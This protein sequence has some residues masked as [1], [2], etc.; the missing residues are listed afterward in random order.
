MTDVEKIEKM[1]E[2]FFTHQGMLKGY[3]F[4]AVRDYHAAEDILQE[5]AIL[6]TQKA[7]DFNFD[8]P[9]S[10][11]L[12]GVAKMH[13]RRW[14]QQSGRR[15]QHVSFD[16]LDLCLT[17]HGEFE[18]AAMLRRETFL[19]DCVESLPSKQRRIMSLRYAEGL[20]CDRISQTMNRSIQ[21]IYSIIKR[22]KSALRECINDKQKK[23]RE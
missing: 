11:W 16:M 6:I 19:V 22:L 21:S 7:S 2:E 15:P 13:I 4:S 3:I 23:S 18:S 20:S 10:P 8:R 14:F 5:M 17:D 1:L 12:T 9:V